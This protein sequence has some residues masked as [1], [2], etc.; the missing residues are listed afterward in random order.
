MGK[1]LGRR[2]V[3]SS[4]SF[5]IFWKKGPSAGIAAAKRWDGR[6][7]AGLIG[8]ATPC[9][10]AHVVGSYRVSNPLHLTVQ[11]AELEDYTTPLQHL[12]DFCQTEY[13]KIKHSIHFIKATLSRL[14][15]YSLS[16]KIC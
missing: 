1:G 2:R 9:H 15:I 11:T 4:S 5:Y 14:L 7:R 16:L 13:D 8:S 6:N 12:S 3:M 10:D